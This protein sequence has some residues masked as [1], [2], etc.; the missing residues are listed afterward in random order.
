MNLFTLIFSKKNKKF[1]G[2]FLIVLLFKSISA[3]F[4]KLSRI[5]NINLPLYKIVLKLILSISNSNFI[6]FLLKK[7][8]KFIYTLF[9]DSS[10]IITNFLFS[11]YKYNKISIIV[12]IEQKYFLLIIQVKKLK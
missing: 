4:L 5:S 1:T 8:N 2:I 6:F 11:K 7:F 3:Q 12:T 10:F 9:S